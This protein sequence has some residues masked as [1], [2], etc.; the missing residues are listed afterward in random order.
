MDLSRRAG[1]LLHP[2]QLPGPYGRGDLGPAART[3]VDQ[4]ASAGVRVWQVLPLGP[5]GY[6]GS[7]YAARSAFAGDAA[8]VSPE[9]LRE[10]GWLTEEDLADAPDW[11]EGAVH[12]EA[13]AYR[14]SLVAKAYE[15]FR[16]EATPEQAAECAAF[17]AQERHWLEDFAL[18]EALKA[19]HGMQA[20]WDWEP[21]YRRL[22]LSRERAAVLAEREQAVGR[23]VFAQ[24]QFQ[25]QWSALR[26]YATSKGIEVFGDAPIFVAKD[27]ADV[28][29]HPELFSLDAAGEPL[30]VAGVPPDG[31]SEDGQL[32]GN[33]LYDWAVHARTGYTWWI[34]R[35]QRL[36]ELCDLVRLDHFRGFA[37]YWEVPACAETAREGKWVPGPGLEL[38]QAIEGALGEVP[39]IAEDLG[40]ITPDVEELMAATGYP[41]MRIVQFA[42]YDEDCEHSFRPE[43]HVENCVAYTGTH[44]NQTSAGWFEGLDACTRERACLDASDPVGDLMGRT[45]GSKAF[46]AILPAQDLLRLG[47]EART[48]APGC[49]E[50]N[51]IWRLSPGQLD[52]AVLSELRERCLEHGRSSLGDAGS[53]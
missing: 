22:L 15:R 10:E 32:W 5:P 39:V 48:N 21:R 26:A 45:L 33:P 3:F 20:F 2:T 34:E 35:I 12:C 38:F 49:A 53:S 19:E 9:L 25:R 41:G 23:E 50:G 27:S 31:F 6:G 43:N 51:W 13:E 52:E 30:V 1:V 47:D 44:D 7:P 17:L 36:A 14:L 46:L 28:W 11:P 37:S 40:E 24:W 18:F 42:Y 29:A 16:R 8:L 4:L